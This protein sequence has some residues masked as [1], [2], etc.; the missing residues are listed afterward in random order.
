MV[1]VRFLDLGEIAMIRHRKLPAWQHEFSCF[2][3]GC[4]HETR[5]RKKICFVANLLAGTA[6]SLVGMTIAILNG[7]LSPE[8]TFAALGVLVAIVAL[9]SATDWNPFRTS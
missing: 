1:P 7:D 6:V 8:D 5:R 3:L 4:P 9:L 2:A